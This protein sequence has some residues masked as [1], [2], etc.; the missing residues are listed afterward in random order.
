MKLSYK[1][2]HSMNDEEYHQVLD[3][4]QDINID[5]YN[6][7]TTLD[8]VRSHWHRSQRNLL[9]GPYNTNNYCESL[10]KQLEV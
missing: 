9:F 7:W 10:V 5:F 2:L 1:A 8:D 4:I 3:D 6:Y